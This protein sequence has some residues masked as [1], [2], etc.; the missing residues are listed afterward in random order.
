MEAVASM[1]TV[2]EAALRVRDAAVRGTYEAGSAHAVLSA[3]S[4]VVDCDHACLARWDPVRRRHVS[5]ANSYPERARE[6]LSNGLHEDPLFA[7][8][9]RPGGLL[10]LHDVPEG[11]RSAS[12]IIR[13]VIEPSG[14]EDGVTQ[15]LFSPDG[16]YVGVLNLSMKGRRRQLRPTDHVLAL[17]D[18]C[19]AAA[20]DV[21]VPPGPVALPPD[22]PADGWTLAVPD[23]PQTA[24][25]PLGGRVPAWLGDVAL[26]SDVVRRAS[27]RRTL[28]A[29]IL[30]PH[31]SR[32]LELRLARRG[33]ATLAECRR[34]VPPAGL[35]P[36][37]LD[38][39]A[40]LTTGLTNREI[41][42]RLFVSTRTVAT[43][44]EHILTKLDAPN[45]VAAASR[46]TAW[47]LEPKAPQV[48]CS[49]R[50]NSRS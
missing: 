25:L 36:R 15:C 32:L 42:E 43:H 22:A 18:D 44:V 28:P 1:E 37:E 45:R 30:V 24:P 8:V 7:L 29:T 14:F 6:H 23:P 48:Q 3:L 26:L 21:L 41:A 46:A 20:V 31:G 27:V 19:L 2:L 47:G 38:V 13:D 35:S 33:A 17:L 50:K 4:E 16:R 39:L 40:E 9:R 12:T 10:W 11:L 5:L 34:V 49:Q